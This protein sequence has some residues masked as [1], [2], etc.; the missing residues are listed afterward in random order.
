MSIVLKVV[1]RYEYDRVDVTLRV[2]GT[3]DTFLDINLSIDE[4]ASF[5]LG[6]L[7]EL[8]PAATLAKHLDPVVDAR[9]SEEPA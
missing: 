3:T 5:P 7:F 4:A 1:E 8:V 2:E 6:A 9:N